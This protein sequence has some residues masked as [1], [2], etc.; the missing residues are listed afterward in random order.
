[1]WDGEKRVREREGKEGRARDTAGWGRM[2]SANLKSLFAIMVLY[3]T[4]SKHKSGRWPKLPNLVWRAFLSRLN[5]MD[6][7]LKH[8][9][10]K[11]DACIPEKSGKCL[12]V[13]LQVP[14]SLRRYGFAHMFVSHCLAMFWFDWSDGRYT[15]YKSVWIVDETMDI[16]TK[17]LRFSTSPLS[18]CGISAIDPCSS[19]SQNSQ[20]KF[21]SG[22]VPKHIAQDVPKQTIQIIL[23]AF[24]YTSGNK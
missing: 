15:W 9:S 16:A 20:R 14:W 5:L 11:L 3:D 22:R 21:G 12:H 7:L 18:W 19:S 23:D 1:M 17:N 24:G 10:C 13:L 8:A 2:L 4:W 6:T